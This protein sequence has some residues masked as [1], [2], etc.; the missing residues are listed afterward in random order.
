M[1][2]AKSELTDDQIAAAYDVE[3]GNGMPSKNAPDMPEPKYDVNT[4]GEH[5]FTWEDRV[6][7]EIFRITVSHPDRT[8]MDFWCVL[9]VQYRRNRDTDPVSIMPG[10]RWNLTSTSSTT[11]QVQSLNRRMPDRGWE[12]RLVQAEDLLRQNVQT[13]DELLDLSTI[14]NPP[15]PSYAVYPLLEENE[16]NIIG[17]DGGSTKSILAQACCIMYTSGESIIAGFTAPKEVRPALYLDYESSSGTQAYRKRLLLEGAGITEQAG[18]IFYKR[19]YS[20]IADA[21]SELYDIIQSRNIGLVIVD[22]GARAVGGETSTENMVIP[23]FNACASWGV[24]VL[25]VVH[26]AKSAESRGPAGVAQW[27]N[28]ARNYWELVKDQ[29]PGQNEV[30]VSL[31][32]DKANDES[33]QEPLNYRIEFTDT[34]IKYHK[35]DVVVSD[36]ILTEMHVSTRMQNYVRENP[37]S[38]V[39]EVATA[40]EKGETHIANE[41]KKN[42]GKLFYGTADKPRRWS[43]ITPSARKQEPSDQKEFYWEKN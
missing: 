20:P 21:A 15:P 28:Q 12:A 5:L 7:G 27:W 36:K 17:A 41:F 13:G 24:T 26:K 37:S 35:E 22:S 11:Q 9:A 32:H 31:R 10:K 43:N 14:E 23:Y 8:G 18:K 40:L 29:T 33:L 34:F 30:Y 25:T 2:V 4:T 3:V 16:H 39:R 42:E 19:M 6:T 1:G 38:T